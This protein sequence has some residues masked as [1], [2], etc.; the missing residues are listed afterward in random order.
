VTRI[1]AVDDAIRSAV[2]PSREV[3]SR[4][5]SF[6]GAKTI[7]GTYQ[8]SPWDFTSSTNKKAP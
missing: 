2:G 5:A 1:M 7:T 4:E 3:Q 6:K 8:V